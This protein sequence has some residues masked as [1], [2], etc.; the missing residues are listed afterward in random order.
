[1]AARVLVIDQ[2]GLVL[3][4]STNVLKGQAVPLPPQ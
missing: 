2:Q 1:L 3:A 4:D